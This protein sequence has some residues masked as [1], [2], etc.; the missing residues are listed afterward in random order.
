LNKWK[1]KEQTAELESNPKQKETTMTLSIT[2]KRFQH[3]PRMSQ[4]TEAFNADISYKGVTIGTAENNGHGGCTFVHLNDKGRAIPEIVA[5]NQIPEFSNGEFNEDSLTNI[6]DSLVEKAIHSKW[7]EKQRKRVGKQLATSVLFS[8][9]GDKDGSFR[10]YKLA[11]KSPEE[12]VAFAK[13]VAGKPDVTRVLNLMPF[14][15]AFQLLVK[16]D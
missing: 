14:D 10:T 4:E 2:L 13:Q 12:I 5:A 7:V 9:K 16:V 3:Y 1:I 6:V 15:E 8:R 11:G